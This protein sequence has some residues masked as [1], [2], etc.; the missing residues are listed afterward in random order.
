[1][2][3]QNPAS[4]EPLVINLD[5]LDKR[6]FDSIAAAESSARTGMTNP[7]YDPGKIPAMDVT[8]K[9][10]KWNNWRLAKVAMRTQPSEQGMKITAVTASH[11]GMRV[12]GSG[13]WDMFSAA[14]GG[15]ESHQTRLELNASFDDF[16]QTIAEVGGGRSFAEGRGEAGLSLSWPT[17]GYAPKLEQITGQLLFNLRD[18]R[19]LTV[20]PGAG[21]ILGLFALQ[22]LPRRL[23][24][25]F[26]DMTNTGL[27]YSTIGGNLTIGNGLARTNAIAVTGPV[28]EILIQ[29]DTDFVSKTYDQT[30]HVLP[31]IGGALPLLG[32]IS[33]GPAAGL[34]ALLADSILRGIG[35]NLDEIGRRRYQLTGDWN[36][37]QW[38]AVTVVTSGQNF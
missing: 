30:I 24:L 34:T 36:N 7:S 5:R 6:L 20:E 10:L 14:Q 3:R 18:G 29:G 11:D 19:I 1:M 13:Q 28:A 15:S 8:V 32:V 9:E 38:R 27:E 12:S 2:L 22:A 35:V 21:R 37:P 23:T 16:G 33:G 4:N 17:P 25:D 31:R 26:S